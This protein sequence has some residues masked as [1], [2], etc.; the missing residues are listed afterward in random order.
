MCRYEIAPTDC[1]RSISSNADLLNVQG[2]GA[3]L[4][5]WRRCLTNALRSISRPPSDARCA[6]FCWRSINSGK[7][8][9][10]Y[11]NGVATRLWQ[12]TGL[13]NEIKG[14]T[15]ISL[16]GGGWQTSA[17]ESL[18]EQNLTLTISILRTATACSFG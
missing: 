6:V 14:N 17:T 4:T 1:S 16:R 10:L 18:S 13:N 8:K 9:S 11:I 7:R 12:N 15:K 2:I 5:T 3:S